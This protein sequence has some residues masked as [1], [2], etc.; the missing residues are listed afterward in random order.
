MAKLSE[1]HENTEIDT[2]KHRLGLRE[3]T[4]FMTFRCFSCFRCVVVKQRLFLPS[5]QRTRDTKPP[6][7]ETLK[8]RNVTEMTPF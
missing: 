1:T 6:P 3:M 2:L 5:N 7:S 4:L 8:H